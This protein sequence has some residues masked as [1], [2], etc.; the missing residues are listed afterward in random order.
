[1]SL[2]G[3]YQIKCSVPGVCC[4]FQSG[5]AEWSHKYSSSAVYCHCFSE[6][7]GKVLL[8]KA[9]HIQVT[10]HEKIKLMLTWKLQPYY[11]VYIVH[12][13]KRE[14]SLSVLPSCQLCEL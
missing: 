2:K 13:T 6:H 1:M 12:A 7:D 9:P 3:I 8:M 11:L 5:C 4:L 14:K 10:E